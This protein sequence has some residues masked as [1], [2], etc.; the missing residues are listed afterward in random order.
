MPV[1]SMGILASATVLRQQV[2]VKTMHGNAEQ[3]LGL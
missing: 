2:M 3:V 1:Y